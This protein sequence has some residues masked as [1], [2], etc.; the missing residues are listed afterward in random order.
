[1]NEK[2]VA[3]TNKKKQN[4][5]NGAIVGAIFG[6]FVI[7]IIIFF[8][9]SKLSIDFALMLTFAPFGFCCLVGLSG[10]IF[11]AIGFLIGWVIPAKN[12]EH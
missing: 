6:M 11:S 5:F 4:G 7:P 9:D 12:D 3:T 8:T 1:M 10:F 2:T